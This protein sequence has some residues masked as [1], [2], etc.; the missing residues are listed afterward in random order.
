M[1][2]TSPARPTEFVLDV[3]DTFDAYCVYCTLQ[4]RIPSEAEYF[5]QVSRT[6]SAVEKIL[7][8]IQA[9]VKP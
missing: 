1:S 6:V 7:S 4:F 2:P 5:L 8:G 9:G 3:S